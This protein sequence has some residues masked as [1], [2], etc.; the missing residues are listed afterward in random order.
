M[1]IASLTPFRYFEVLKASKDAVLTA[2]VTGSV[3]VVIPLMVEAVS[4]LFDERNMGQS[5]GH[6]RSEF[7]IPLGYSFPDLGKVIS[8][9]FIPF[10]AWFYGSTI[11]LGDFPSILLMG[12][13][14]A[15][16]KLTVAIPFLLESQ[17]LPMDI[18]QLFLLSGVVAGRFAD[19]ACRHAHHE[20]HNI[21]F[22]RHGGCS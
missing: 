21:D 6:P 11:A 16:G 12:L 20:L 14:L 18:F 7:V 17:G 9:I 5:E 4:R 8:L 2:F 3:F 15:F 22:L 19:I 1:T 10:A 13:L